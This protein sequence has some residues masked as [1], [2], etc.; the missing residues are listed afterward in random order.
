MAL[1]EEREAIIRKNLTKDAAAIRREFGAKWAEW[2][3]DN[4]G[5]RFVTIKVNAF[6]R[7][8]RGELPGEEHK[9]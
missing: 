8:R 3:M 5:A 6:K 1:T 9:P 7:M 2:W 4:Y